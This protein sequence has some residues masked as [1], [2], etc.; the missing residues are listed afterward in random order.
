M[1]C[2][3]EGA[4][5]C[6]CFRTGGLSEDNVSQSIRWDHG[7]IEP[8]CAYVNTN[9]LWHSD[10]CST[11]KFF[12]CSLSDR[13]IYH[14]IA[15]SWDKASEYCQNMSGHLVNM[16]DTSANIFKLP[17]WIGAYQRNYIWSWV[18]N[19]TPALTRWAKNEPQSQDCASYNVSTKNYIR[20]SCSKKLHP[21]CL[22]DNLLVVKE[23]KTWE[24]AL[25]HCLKL[26]VCKTG[27]LQ[28]NHKYNLLS[29]D[30]QSDYNYIRDRIYR[31]TTT[32]V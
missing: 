18:G 13:I 22:N 24:E 30:E 31:A 23:N 10:L 6:I 16:D 25:N 15:K 17:G 3:T 12:Y 19:F 14:K 4:K 20:A 2:K 11:E 8:L 9:K 26:S 29:L 1:Q 27:T 5:G 21:L 28:C 7:K 32:E